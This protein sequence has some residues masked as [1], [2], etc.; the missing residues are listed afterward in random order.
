VAQAAPSSGIGRLVLL[1]VQPTHP[2][3]GFGY[4]A[5]G[6]AGGGAQPILRFVEKPDA[7]QA[8][9]YLR[10]GYLWNSGNF[11]VSVR[12]LNDE[13]QVHAPQVLRW[14]AAAVKA[15]RRRG[16]AQVLSDDFRKAPKISIDY[17][18][19]EKTRL[20]SV[21]PVHFS[22]SDVGAWDAV[23]DA[24]ARD[25]DGNATPPGSILL[26]ARNCLV[27]PARDGRVALLGVENLA[28]IADG[29][30]LLV[31]NID[32]AQDVKRIAAA[33]G[34]ETGAR[35]AAFADLRAARDF[36]DVWARTSALPLWWTVGA[37]HA[38]GGFHEA[39]SLDGKPLNLPRRVRV[40]ARQTYVYA[41][42]SLAGWSGP[43]LQAARH[44][45]ADLRRRYRRP[46]GL[47]RSL[48]AVDGAVL[49]DGAMLYDQAFVLLALATLHRAEPLEA[50]HAAEA[51]HLRDALARLRHPGG[52][53]RE[54]GAQP[55]QANP[56][57][58][59]LEAALAWTEAGGDRGWAALAEEI[60]ELALAHFIQPDGTLREVY[61]RRWSPAPGAAGARVEPG[62]LFEWAWLLHRFG[63]GFGARRAV[64]AAH[65]LYATA[66]RHVDPGRGVAVNAVTAAGEVVD[67]SARLWPQAEYLKAALRLDGDATD[68]APRAAAA[69]AA[70]LR[71]S[72]QG[73]WRDR[74]RADGG[75][76]AEPSPA[77]SLYHIV[78]AAL[79]LA[80]VEAAGAS[81]PAPRAASSAATR[82]SQRL[83]A[84]AA[85]A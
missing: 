28:V 47:F 60:V 81:R 73:A 6:G 2:A 33:A 80:A 5:A 45:L 19:M 41:A 78:G 16:S 62:H 84:G 82:P 18:L 67:P 20:A 26:D 48:A 55:F 70:Y 39:L 36:F 83:A 1:G 32:R 53:F 11:V 52:G 49:D 10:C 72:V 29:D 13:L 71:T 9:D 34:R 44:G 31:C 64:Q 4:I 58:H 65:R 63:Q 25:A 85:H 43:W 75:F 74:M 27:R 40:Q 3:T 17:A 38:G 7:A 66:L 56:H 24:S 46:D 42:A 54:A 69:L 61:D 76:A 68:R 50:G 15:A 79:E 30:D 8:A 22:W 51:L 57:M 35:P 12:T 14:A 77:S 37:D 59:L 21:L 23:R